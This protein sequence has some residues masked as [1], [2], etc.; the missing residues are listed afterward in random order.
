M[1]SVKPAEV[2]NMNSNNILYLPPLSFDFAFDYTLF[3]P[4]TSSW[5]KVKRYEPILEGSLKAGEVENFP[6][7]LCCIWACSSVLS[8]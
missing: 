5:G 4:V 3:K 6:R 2:N 8:G 1:K 7:K